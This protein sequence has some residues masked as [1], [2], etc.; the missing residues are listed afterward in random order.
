[1][2]GRINNGGARKGAGWRQEGGWKED[3]GLGGRS[4]DVFGY[5]LESP[6]R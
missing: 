4:V 1:M 3:G 5:L 6:N 2:D